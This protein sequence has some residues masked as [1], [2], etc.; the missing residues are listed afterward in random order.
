M[1]SIL[2]LASGPALLAGLVLF[3]N[4]PSPE[5]LDFDSVR[6]AV[7]YA[8]KTLAGD[9]DTE[10]ESGWSFP[11]CGGKADKRPP[12]ETYAAVIVRFEYSDECQRPAG[13]LCQ[14][15]SRNGRAPLEAD[16]ARVLFVRPYPT[17]P[18]GLRI[19]Q[20]GYHPF[21]RTINV[22][23]GSITVIDDIVLERVTKENGGELIGRIWLE[24]RDDLE[25]IPIFLGGEKVET[26]PKGEFRFEGVPSGNETLRTQI[27]GFLVN[28]VAVTLERR[29]RTTAVLKGYQNRAARLRW[30][31]QPE[32]SRDLSSGLVLGETVVDTRQRQP[33]SFSDDSTN[34]S[35]H[36]D[37]HL[38]QQDAELL[39]VGS[40]G[41]RGTGMIRLSNIEFDEVL[42]APNVSYE[43]GSFPLSEGDVFIFKTTDGE[44]YAKLEVIEVVAGVAAKEKAYADMA[45]QPL[46][47]DE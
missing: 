31:Y 30:A 23:P 42:Q 34:G 45:R 39:I 28:P 10:D 18:V 7:S 26:G 3:G 22:S 11:G 44:H 6:E 1:L 25:G 21:A 35:S 37:F 13:L 4:H 5:A 14:S 47:E 12:S 33:F 20:P 15:I 43:R 29:K 27:E 2:K 41:S 36:R 32:K 19:R 40:A 24:D 8:E 9:S 38:Q 16:K 46:E 17:Q